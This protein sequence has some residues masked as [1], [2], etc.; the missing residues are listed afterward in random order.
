[1]YFPPLRSILDIIGSSPEEFANDSTI[2]VP[3][4]LM[5]LLLQVAIA[6]SD[7]NE[8]GYA[9]TNPDVADAVAKDAI[10]SALMHYVSYGYF[11]GR[12]GAMPSVDEAWYLRTYPDVSQ[13]IRSKR[14][15]AAPEHF[16]VMGAA[17]GRAPSRQYE[18][19]AFQWKTAI[20]GKQPTASAK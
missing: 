20:L 7:F 6:S 13:A 3:T 12:L 11:E 14:I 5:R 16:N 15:S 8:S 4:G 10:S 2:E 17:E 1:M 18:A 19:E 9:V